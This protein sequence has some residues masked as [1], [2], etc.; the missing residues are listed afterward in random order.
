MIVPTQLSHSAIR[1][2]S[3]G[4]ESLFESAFHTARQPNPVFC[5]PDFLE[6]IEAYRSQPIGKRAALLLQRLL[7][8][9]ERLHYKSTQGDNKGWRRSRLGG[10]SGSHFYAWWAPKG[11]I[12]FKSHPG[13]ADAPSGAL[14]LRDIRHHDDHSPL[15]SQSFPDDYL[16]ITVPEVRREEFG[17]APWTPQQAKF[18]SARDSVRVLKGH[19]G[20]GKTTA[21]LHAADQTTASNILYLTYSSDLA[22]LARSFFD[23]YCTSLPP[24]PRHDLSPVSSCS[25]SV[26]IFRPRSSPN[27][28]NASAPKWLPYP[29]PSAPGPTTFRPFTTNFMPTSSAPPYPPASA[30]SPPP[31]RSE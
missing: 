6:R 7:I 18:A 17:P 15:H 30:D 24:V 8:D 14:F 20:S 9:P 5:H 27:P 21:L 22:A 23:R 13:F 26:S 16:P 1:R 28:A 2:Y 12:P 25:C 19:P 10:S 3:I 29:A 31:V 4:V 11:A